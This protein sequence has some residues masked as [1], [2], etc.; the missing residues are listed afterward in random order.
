[1]NKEEQIIEMLGKIMDEH[2]QTLEK[3]GTQLKEHGQ[4]LTALRADQEHVKAELDGMKIS[5]AKEFGGLKEE[6][7]T[8]V[9]NQEILRNDTW[10]NKVDIQRM[11][12]GASSRLATYKLRLPGWEVVRCCPRKGRT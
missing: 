7:N 3:H 4:I 6:V 10:A 2:S 8:S 1:M 9:I 5:N 11:N 12:K